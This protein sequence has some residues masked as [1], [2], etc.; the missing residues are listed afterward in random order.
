MAK[1]YVCPQCNNRYSYKAGLNQHLTY[2][3][4]KEPQFCCSQEG[5]GY[6]TKRKGNLQT[7]LGIK[8]RI[9]RRNFKD[10]LTSLQKE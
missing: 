7:H 2:E 5:C 1:K 6:K 4:G 10:N 8:H 3:C 9:F